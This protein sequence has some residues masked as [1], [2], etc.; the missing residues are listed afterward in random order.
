MQD[1]ALSLLQT[2]AAVQRHTDDSEDAT[3]PAATTATTTTAEQDCFGAHARDSFFV[4][5]GIILRHK[6]SGNI[7]KVKAMTCKAEGPEP[8]STTWLT[9]I[10]V[11]DMTMA[12]EVP[13]EYFGIRNRAH[14]NVSYKWMLVAGGSPFGGFAAK[15]ANYNQTLYFPVVPTAYAPNETVTAA[16]NA[17]WQSDSVALGLIDLFSHSP[18]V[19]VNLPMAVATGTRLTVENG[20]WS[21]LNQTGAVSDWFDFAVY[22]GIEIAWAYAPSV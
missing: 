13:S 20:A 11:P 5:G 3:A 8:L 1:E 9:P 18:H 14:S 15:P 21:F 7:V 12:H 6:A 17:Q 10:V 19:I 16:A 2:R 22:P 4:V